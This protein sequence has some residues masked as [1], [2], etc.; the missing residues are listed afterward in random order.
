MRKRGYV[1]LPLNWTY[2]VSGGFNNSS[3]I[4]VIYTIQHVVRHIF[5]LTLGLKL[6]I[7]QRFGSPT[8]MVNTFSKSFL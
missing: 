1:T 2:I 5:S 3:N 7:G 8:W 4:R 6:E